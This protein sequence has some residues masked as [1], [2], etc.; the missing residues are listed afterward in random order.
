LAN[1]VT[2]EE[3]RRDDIPPRPHRPARIIAVVPT[4]GHHRHGHRAATRID[5]AAVEGHPRDGVAAPR[6]DLERR[7]ARRR[8]AEHRLGDGQEAGVQV[9]RVPV[10]LARAA[11]RDEN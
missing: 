3:R 9:L 10:D 7:V 4:S 11:G 2:D 1:A 6:M 8:D 5:G